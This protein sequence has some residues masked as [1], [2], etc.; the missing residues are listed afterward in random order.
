[1][2][3]KWTTRYSLAA[4][5]TAILIISVA[6]FVNPNV[7]PQASAKSTFTVMLTDPPN[8]PAGTTVLNLTYSDISLHVA[9]TDGTAAW[10]SVQGSGTI[11]S[12]SLVNMSQTLASTTIPT[13]SAV[14]KIQFT[15]VNVDAVIN[16]TTYNVT[17][18]SNT[19]VLSVANSKVNQT[20]SGVLVD[21]NPTLLQIQ[22]VDTNG[23][24]VDYYV[25]MPS[26]TAT[27]VN[28]IDQA[29]VKVGTIV[30]IGEHDRAR[31]TNVVADF[32]QNISIESASLATNGNSTNLSVTLKNNG[33]VTLRIFGLM[34]QGQFNTPQNTNDQFQMPPQG[35]G[36]GGMGGP[37][38]V[39]FQINNTSLVPLFGAG[40]G[41]QP[42][43]PQNA[44]PNLPPQTNT[45]MQPPNPQNESFTQTPKS[46]PQIQ[47]GQQMQP[48][49]PQNARPNPPQR[50]RNDTQPMNPQSGPHDD[51][52]GNAASSS[53][54]LQP[55]QTVT[56]SFS[57]IIE[58]PQ[59]GDSA[60]SAITP[61]V[62]NNYAIQLTGEGFQTYTVTATS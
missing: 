12:F 46:G 14:D 30:G 42:M 49:N 9:Y 53:L 24:P 7:I 16:G 51:R 40:P 50:P 20:L 48:M 28:S 23:N 22:S 11:N 2:M 36:F 61:I 58:L 59:G 1:M 19:L 33:D 54:A 3:R 43:N 41:M 31:L 13:G 32:S 4:V 60:N 38:T 8:V 39:P 37:N 27:V 17:T 25:L 21:F 55:G 57:G 56:L 18:L 26:A 6:M 10:I 52:N 45:N 29:Q 34:L 35:P 15:I 62:G 5:L 44:A 47:L